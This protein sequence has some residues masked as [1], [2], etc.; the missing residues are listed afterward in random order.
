MKLIKVKA[1]KTNSQNHETD[2]RKNKGEKKQQF[3]KLTKLEVQMQP[4]VRYYQ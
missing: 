2:T 1:S 3:E 4:K